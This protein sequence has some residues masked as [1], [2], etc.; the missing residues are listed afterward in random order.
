MEGFRLHQPLNCPGQLYTIMV[1]FWAHSPHHKASVQT[2]YVKLPIGSLET[3]YFNQCMI[4]S[5][6]SYIQ[7]NSVTFYPSLSKICKLLVVCFIC[8]FVSSRS[9]ESFHH[10]VHQDTL[11]YDTW[12]GPISGIIGP[13]VS[14]PRGTMISAIARQASILYS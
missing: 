4:N 1:S 14:I 8:V 3:V 5:C 11:H 12:K 13:M 10:S 6:K 7:L 9:S 2:F